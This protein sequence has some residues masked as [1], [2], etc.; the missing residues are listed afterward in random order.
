MAGGVE[1]AAARLVWDTM[2]RKA[3]YRRP[4][5]AVSIP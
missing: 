2:P 1:G 5:R 4:F 3:E